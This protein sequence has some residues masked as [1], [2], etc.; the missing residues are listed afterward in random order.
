MAAEQRIIGGGLLIGGIAVALILLYLFNWGGMSAPN[1]VEEL[2][3]SVYPAYAKAESLRDY[4][5]MRREAKQALELIEKGGA[6]GVMKHLQGTATGGG[7]EAKA[8]YAL[9]KEGVFEKNAEGLFSHAG[10]WFQEGTHRALS[11]VAEAV[12][13]GMKVLRQLR[14]TAE[15]T[16][17]ALGEARTGSGKEISLPEAKSPGPEEI[18]IVDP[19]PIFSHDEAHFAVFGVRA[20]V[21]TDALATPNPGGKATSARLRW[22]RDIVTS[23]LSRQVDGIPEQAESLKGLATRIELGART[24]SGDPAAAKALEAILKRGAEGAIA[25]LPEEAK[26]AF[27][28]SRALFEKGDVLARVLRREAA[29]LAPYLSTIRAL[30]A[31]FGSEFAA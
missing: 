22:N 26:A 17:A 25:R 29:M 9:A 30:A 23:G 11:D 18:P 28:P 14:E 21:V 27:E 3:K 7:K 15:A 24:A 12:D 16:H 2:E 1:A 6:V 20:E 10:E 13:E 5:G 4:V 31:V 19:N 8:L